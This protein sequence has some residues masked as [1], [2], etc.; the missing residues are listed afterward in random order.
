VE[1]RRRRSAEAESQA[2][3]SEMA[4]MNRRVAMGGLAA[5]IAHELN[6][7]LGAI[8]N[9]AGAAQILIKADPPKLHD[10]AE[11]LDDIKQDDM[12]ASEVITRIRT[13]LRKAEVEV[14]D[15]DLNEA[16]SETVKLLASDAAAHEI[17]LSTD[18]DPGLPK[19]R[20]DRVQIQQ[21]LINLGLNAIEAMRDQPGAKRRLVIRSV[22]A[23]DKTA[24]VS[25][26]DSGPGIPLE[27]LPRIFEPFVTSKSAG[28]G[29]GLSI[30]RTIVEAHGGRIR[31]ENLL[32][33]G[34]AIHFTLP[35]AAAAQ[36]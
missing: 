12:R 5:S 17:A 19:V 25:V 4:H 15:L 13:M 35:F 30:S 34:A 11:I 20:A 10:V 33:G 9:N 29:L 14:G 3:F 24:E 22:R 8:Y 36:A 2:R 31:A 23:N 6:Q 32:E 7:P 27:V 26:V 21:V 18:L 16:I 1:R 28:M